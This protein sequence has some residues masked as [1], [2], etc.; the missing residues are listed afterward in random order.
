MSHVRSFPRRRDGEFTFEVQHFGEGLCGGP[1]VKALAGGIVVG[2]DEI[3]EAL[4]WERCEVGF[5][6][7]EATHAADRILDTALLPGGVGV[8]EEG[9]EGQPVQGTVARELGAIIEGDG[10][11]QLRWHALEQPDEM[12][13]NAV[14]GFV[15]RSRRQQQ[16]GL[17]LMHGQDRLTISG[18][19]HEIGFPVTWGF[20][21]GRR[22][23]PFSHGNT[24]FNEGCGAAAPSAAA[25]PPTLA[26]R[27]I[28]APTPVLGTGD[29]GVDE[30]ID[31]L[32]ADDLAAS[33]AGEPSGDLLGRP[34]AGQTLQDSA[35]Q[36][37][38]PFQP[39]ARPAPRLP[40]F[41]GETWFVAMGGAAIAS[42]LTRDRRWRAIQSCSDLPDRMPLGL[43]TGNL[44]SVLQ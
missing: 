42:Y 4:V 3:V 18:E 24:A 31:A 2:A 13:S 39:R 26:A 34:A 25:A 21:V 35:A 12:A 19:Q 17:A 9:L 30:A 37:G 22:G 29:L 20:A 6:R 23:G 8:A 38:L 14:G 36:A 41:V 40:L 5:A 43:K 32:V 16:A 33:F 10:L 28:A 7:D 44:A 1:E 27:Q 11:A 15:R